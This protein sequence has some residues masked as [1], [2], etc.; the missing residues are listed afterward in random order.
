[1]GVYFD[2]LLTTPWK[3]GP[4]WNTV[5][6]YVPLAYE[7]PLTLKVKKRCSEVR[8]SPV[9]FSEG[10]WVDLWGS[11]LLCSVGLW[12]DQCYYGLG[13]AVGIPGSEQWKD[14]SNQPAL[15]GMH[16]MNWSDGFYGHSV[17]SS[18]WTVNHILDPS[19]RIFMGGGGTGKFVF[20]K[21]TSI[22]EH[23]YIPGVLKMVLVFTK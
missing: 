23:F 10:L 16:A 15:K 18:F 11:P 21:R 12:P 3:L 7:W 20:W 6:R 19:R 13:R 4:C 22:Y 2:S 14:F 8:E 17:C 5:Y 9:L 1:M